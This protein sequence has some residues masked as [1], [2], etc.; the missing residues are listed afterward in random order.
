MLS[1]SR[2]TA[3]HILQYKLLTFILE[4]DTRRKGVTGPTK[5]SFQNQNFFLTF[6]M[7][8]QPDHSFQDPSILGTF[9]IPDR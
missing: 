4:F 1:N 5:I 9:A 2:N 3:F 7:L 8:E 6:K